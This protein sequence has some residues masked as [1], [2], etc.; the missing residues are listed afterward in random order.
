[1]K[2]QTPDKARKSG[3]GAKPASKCGWKPVSELFPPPAPLPELDSLP[4]ML[5]EV[6]PLNGRH[7]KSLPGDIGELSETLTCQ[8]GRLAMPYWQRPNYVSAYLYYFLPWNLLRLARLLRGLRLPPPRDGAWLLDAGSGPLTVPLALWLTRPEWR[9]LK[10]HILALDSARQP[11]ILGLKLLNMLALRCGVSPWTVT[12]A[13]DPLEALPRRLPRDAMPWLITAANAL[14]E[15]REQTARHGS[16]GDENERRAGRLGGLLR[17]WEPL[18]TRAP[19]LIAEPGTRL[20][21]DTI[22]RLRALALEL[23]LA[24]LA[25]CTHDSP[26]PLL[27]DKKRWC[28]FV[29]TAQD[30]PDWLKT[31]SREARLYKTSLSLAPLLLDMPRG[32]RPE[33]GNTLPLRVISQPFEA[34]GGMARYACSAC[35]LCL[36]PD[37]AGAVSGALCIGKPE[38]VLDAHSG[39]QI[40]RP[41]QC[42]VNTP[43]AG[44]PELKGKKQ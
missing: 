27:E 3:G 15:M 41:V 20:G 40:V 12:L 21:G 9:K 17:A 24:P 19:L 22:G 8:R 5:N 42:K 30:A 11:L 43:K 2:K 38:G 44:R 23:G 4:D 36:M 29:F 31:L 26:C 37:A 6:W 33:D 13:V 35:G 34:A 18:W 14:N 39:A 10:L 28:H 25:P 32:K 16:S 1:M 7:R